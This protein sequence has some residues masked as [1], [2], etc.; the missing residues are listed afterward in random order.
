MIAS[1]DVVEGGLV[2]ILPALLES[3]EVML[4]GVEVGRVRRQEEQRGAGGGDE[5]RRLGRFVKRGIIEDDEMLGVE[6][7]A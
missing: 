7:R 6:A 5:L 2:L 4:N 1:H 3:G